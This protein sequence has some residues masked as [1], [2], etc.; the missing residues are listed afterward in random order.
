M[1]SSKKRFRKRFAALALS[2]CLLIPGLTGNAD[3]LSEIQAEINQAQASMADLEAERAEIDARLNTLAHDETKAVEY[4]SALQAKIDNLEA[5]IDEAIVRMNQLDQEI[6]VLEAKNAKAEEEVQDTMT[7]FTESLVALYKSG[8]GN[9]N[10]AALDAVLNSESF[11]EYDMMLKALDGATNFNQQVVD[12]INAYIE[13]TAAARADCQDK[14]EEAAQLKQN[15]ESNQNELRVAY[16][17]NQAAIQ[18]IAELREALEDRAAAVARERTEADAHYAAQVQ[19][20]ADQ[21]EANERAKTAG[22]AAGNAGGGNAGNGSGGNGGSAGNG[23]ADKDRDGEGTD[24]DQDQD[25]DREGLTPGE[26]LDPETDPAEGLEDPDGED[27]SEGHSDGAE[28]DGEY[29]GEEDNYEEDWPEDGSVPG[30][31]VSAAGDDGDNTSVGSAENDG[32]WDGTPDGSVFDGSFIWPLPGG[33]VTQYY[34]PDVGHNGL[35]MAAGYGQD[36]VAAASGVVIEVNSTD[37]WGMSW[38][39]YVRIDHDGVITTRYAHMS[40]TAVF[41]GDYVTQGQTIGYEGS[42]GESTGSHL[43]FEVAIN[44]ARVD[45]YNYLK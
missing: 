4:Q 31:L 22:N 37:D 21:E 30:T 42:T 18:E 45:P 44:G 8:A 15:L 7:V 14:K 11:Y 33:V 6:L 26:G 9:G 38:G 20:K 35:D 17:E 10:L 12:K 36:I 23:S 2:I 13:E 1:Q 41:E 25:Q 16:E 32:S 43:H 40:A 3:S 19:R 24:Q 29:G 39:Y 34:N 27:G 5:Q 28:D